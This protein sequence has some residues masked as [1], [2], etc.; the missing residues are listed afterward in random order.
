MKSRKI[1]QNMI[2]QSLTLS[3]LFPLLFLFGRLC[4][5][6]LLCFEGFDESRHF[7]LRQN[8]YFC[9]VVISGKC[10]HFH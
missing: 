10:R 2:N 8:S 1:A 5:L 6:L 3:G 9:F 7:L 4:L